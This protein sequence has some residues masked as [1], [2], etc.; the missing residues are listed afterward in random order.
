[1]NPADPDTLRLRPT[2]DEIAELPLFVGLGLDR[3]ELLTTDAQFDAA[4]RAIENAGRVG[5]DTETKPTFTKDAVREGPHVIQFAL[6]DRAF[7]VQV[8]ANPPI[9]FLRAVI[10]SDRIVKVGFGL[11]SDR[12]LLM[13]KLGIELRGVVELTQVLRALRYKHALGVRAAV[14]IVL[15]RRFQKSK[16]VTTSNWAV[17]KLAAN[18]VLYAAN[19]AYAALAVFEALQAA[20][21]RPIPP[22]DP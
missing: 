13:K 11:A 7:I 16:S 19:D 5:F 2:R 10:G 3:I 6:H 20:A 1:M 4:R 8:G 22:T 9:D 18:Q 15:G 14:A 12:G 17:P 21:G